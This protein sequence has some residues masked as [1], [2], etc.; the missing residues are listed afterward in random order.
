M[1]ECENSTKKNFCCLYSSGSRLQSLTQGT[2]KTITM[3]GK[4][5]FL[6]E[7]ENRTLEQLGLLD[8]KVVFYSVCKH[9]QTIENVEYKGKG[10]SS[11]VF[12]KYPVCTDV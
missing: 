10:S 6:L 2:A 12:N 9:K 4:S 5:V 11:I 3:T 7:A 8:S 1:S